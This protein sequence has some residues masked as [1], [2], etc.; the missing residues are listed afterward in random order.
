MNGTFLLTA[1]A[2]GAV[3]MVKKALAEGIPVNYTNNVGL[4][5]LHIACHH[6]FIHVVNVL[7]AAGADV[8]A[9]VS[10]TGHTPLVIAA[11]GGFTDKE[12]EENFASSTFLKER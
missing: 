2:A 5:A 10:D 9:T 11:A 12:I 4:Q 1:C 8:N 3:D 7:I 6:G